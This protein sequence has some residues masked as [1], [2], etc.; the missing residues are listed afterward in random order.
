MRIIFVAIGSSARGSGGSMPFRLNNGPKIKVRNGYYYRLEISPGDHV[1]RGPG[2]MWGVYGPLS[3]H[4]KVHVE[5][6]Q[7]IYFA[8][9]S[10]PFIGQIFEV[11]E[12]QNDARDSVSKLKA[13]N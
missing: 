4:Q 10:V 12:D 13:Q 8:D 2:G 9:Y 11:A 7:T 1:L 5:P 6:G 3:D